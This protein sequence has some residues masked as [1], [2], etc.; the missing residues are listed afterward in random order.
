MIL[1]SMN[2]ISTPLLLIY[3]SCYIS[4]TCSLA[5][6]MFLVDVSGNIT[7]KD[8][9]NWDRVLWFLNDAITVL[10]RLGNMRF[11]MVLFNEEAHL[12]FNLDTFSN[13]S[14]VLNNVSSLSY[15]TYMGGTSNI[16]SGLHLIR[17]EVLPKARP[18]AAK[19]IILVTDTES[20]DEV[21]F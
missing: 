13:T 10:N 1:M 21:L 17:I 19:I 14:K 2:C 3:K 4:V 16:T 6:V 15:N 20:G 5:D 7:G 8:S 12:Q 9:W 18:D 11:S